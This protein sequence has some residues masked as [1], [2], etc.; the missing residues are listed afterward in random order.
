MPS[1]IE[2][3]FRTLRACEFG[4]LDEQGHA[5][6]DYTGTALYADS[7]VRGHAA[8]LGGSI[9]GNPHSDSPSSRDST[10]HVEAARAAVLRHF[11]AD[12]AEYAV[13][14]TGNASGALRL[15]GEAYPFA[16][17]SRFVLSADNHNSVNGI[18]RF[19]ERAGADVRYVPLDGE[20]RMADPEPVL[21]G[22]DRS[23][24]NLFAFPAQSNFSGVRHPLALVGQAKEM[25]YDVLL[26]A[27]AFVPTSALRLR[28]VRPDFVALSFYKMFGYPTGVG[29][30]IARREALARL[31]RPWFAGGTVEFVSTQ[32]PLHMLKDGAEAFEDGTVNFLGIAAVPAGL[33]LLEE[34]GMQRLGYHLA[35]LTRLLLN[36]LSEMRHPCGAPLV[37][38]YGPHDGEDRGATV[39][40]NIL[41][42]DGHA[43]D[44]EIVET[45]AA[46]AGVSVR[47]GCFCNPGAAEHAF[48]FPAKNS[49]C[50]LRVLARDGFTTGRFRRCL[51]GPPVGAV[52]VS[53][54]V[55]TVESDLRRFL[56]VVESFR[57]EAGHR[58]RRE[59]AA[60]VIGTPGAAA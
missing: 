56:T 13:C 11:D 57:G 45:R 46:Q 4:R 58:A 37:R 31:R 60:G 30:L 17:G 3:Y 41:N 34:V 29:A 24:P 15:V 1:Q 7:L 14:F 9:L 43:V 49:L 8:L 12:P 23:A 54:G 26:D 27:A 32:H 55:A 25:G 18:R 36:A 20:M 16:A 44:Y 39:A 50:C 51:A 47:G 5:Y 53:L 38:I 35:G 33:R 6:L 59:P 28:D 52:R 22:A 10:A 19:A 42:R 40:L 2:A 21:A 48:A